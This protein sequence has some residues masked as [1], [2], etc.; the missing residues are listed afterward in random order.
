MFIVIP[1]RNTKPGDPQDGMAATVRTN[2]D[3]LFLQGL[4]AIPVGGSPTGTSG[5][6]VSPQGRSKTERKF[7]QTFMHPFAVIR[8][9]AS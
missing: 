7:F 8:R 2:K 1:A 4:F 6:P 9:N 3:G 5:S